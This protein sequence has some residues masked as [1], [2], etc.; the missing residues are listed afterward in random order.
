MHDDYESPKQEAIS[1][2]DVN[3]AGRDLHLSNNNSFN[4]TLYVGIFFIVILALG[5]LTWFLSIGQNKN[6]QNQTEEVS[7]LVSLQ[8]QH[9]PRFHKL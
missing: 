9:T 1:G 4:A 5:G 2:R 3:Q 7:K 6:E 8:T